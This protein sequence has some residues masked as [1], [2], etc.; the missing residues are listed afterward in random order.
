[1]K[2]SVHLLSPDLRSEAVFVLHDVQILYHIIVI[3]YYAYCFPCTLDAFALG[4]PIFYWREVL[5]SCN[6][7]NSGMLNNSSLGIYILF[8]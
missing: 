7:N 3:V 8:M 5:P 1:M 2:H 6:F 4:L